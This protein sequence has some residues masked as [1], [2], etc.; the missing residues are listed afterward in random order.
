[1]S[2]PEC[3]SN[4]NIQIIATYV[5]SKLGGCCDLFEGLPYPADEYTCADEFFLNEDEWTTFENFEKIFRRARRLVDEPSFFFQCGASSATLASWGRFQVFARVF[6][7]PNDGY[8]R[9]PF[10]NK[11][12]DDTKE[13]EVLV[14]PAYDRGLNKMRTLLKVEFHEDMDPHRDYIGDP[15][16]RGILSSIPTLWGLPP[17]SIRQV[18][19]PYDPTVLLNHEPEFSHFGLDARTE[20]NRLILRDP[21]SGQ[22]RTVGERVV[23]APQSVN[24]RWLFLGKHA[25]CSRHETDQAAFK[26]EAFLTTETVR[27]GDCVILEAGE[28]YGGPYFVLE[29]TYERLSFLRRIPH[30]FHW[31]RNSGQSAMGMVETIDRLR[32][33]IKAKNDAYRALSKTNLVL[34]EAK[35]RLAEQARDLEL[36]VK[37]RTQAL[38]LARENLMSL[39]RQLESTVNAQV[40]QLQRYHELRR[41][42]SPRLTEEILRQGREFGNEPRRKLMTVVFYYIR[43]FSTLTDNLEPEEIFQ[44]LNH[45][46]SEMVKIVHHYDGTLNKIIGDGLLIFFGDPIAVEDHAERAVRMAVDMQRKVSQLQNDWQI[47]GQSIGVGIGI[48]TGFMTLGTIGSDS[49]KDYTVIGTQVNLAARLESMAKPGQILVAHRTYCRVKDHVEAEAIGEIRVK[50]IHFP[51]MVY[52]VKTATVG[53]GGHLIAI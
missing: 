23:L 9:L 29:V 17:A 4:R 20:G 7:Q 35:E 30:L 33:S 28:I 6:A 50:G 40:L 44:I 24:G 34:E 51:V 53:P 11:N 39:N 18:M 42:L 46:Q 10:F 32:M 22:S 8:E 47:F 49:F 45:Y 36:K 3:I 2:R 14:P 27:A 1:M 43:G 12:L 37:Q 31:W 25:P 15:Y 19:N 5:A 26:R 52:N 21:S 16:L 48:S 38:E 13:I 41:Y